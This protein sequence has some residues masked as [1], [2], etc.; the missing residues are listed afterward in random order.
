MLLARS[1]PKTHSGKMFGC[2]VRLSDDYV[3]GSV[4]S[5][6]TSTFAPSVIQRKLSIIAAESKILSP[7]SQMMNSSVKVSPPTIGAWVVSHA[8]AP[9][10]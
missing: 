6:P 7:V 10:V 4:K 9:P 1:I 3:L 5:V 2:C 8:V